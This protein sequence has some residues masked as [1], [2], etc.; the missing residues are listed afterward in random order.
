MKN[1]LI[2]ALLMLL[3]ACSQ[4]ADWDYDKSVKFSNYKTFAWIEDASL[5]KS[6]SNYQI[7]ELME[8]RVRNAIYTQL[9]EQHNMT[10]VDA[11]QADVLINYHAS[12]DKELDID[13]INT[14]YHARWNYWGFGYQKETSAREYEV[15]TL[16]IDVVDRVSNQLIWRGAK[17]GRLKK[18]QKP[19]QREAS[20]NKTVEAIL[21]NFPPK[22]DH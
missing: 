1:I 20:V 22:D 17:E 7:N 11:T 4:T 16:V 14:G 10:M 15:G 12:V 13:T 21:S 2:V 6:S 3:T 18:K 9:T 5:T 8:K 19:E